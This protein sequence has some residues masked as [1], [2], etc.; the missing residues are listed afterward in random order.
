MQ[1]LAPRSARR[2]ESLEVIPRQRARD[3]APFPQRGAI[4]EQQCRRRRQPERNAGHHT[5]GDGIPELLVHRPCEEGETAREDG[6][7]E[8][9]AGLG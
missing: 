1:R 2:P 9:V 8:A 4:D 5:R 3:S 7:D 6:A